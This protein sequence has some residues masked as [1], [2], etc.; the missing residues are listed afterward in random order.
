MLTVYKLLLVAVG[1]AILLRFRRQGAAEAACWSL[2]GVY[3]AILVVWSRYH[4]Y[5]EF[6]LNDPATVRPPLIF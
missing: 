3:A 2:V 6:C 4:D 1:T 5:V